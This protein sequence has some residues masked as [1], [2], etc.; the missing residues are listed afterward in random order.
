M[1]KPIKM[2]E[3][4]ESNEMINSKTSCEC[5]ICYE[6]LGETNVCITK[7]GHKF[8]IGCLFRHSERSNDC[9]MCREQI[10]DNFENRNNR[11]RSASFNDDEFINRINEGLSVPVDDLDNFMRR[12]WTRPQVVRSTYNVVDIPDN[13][14]ENNVIDLTNDDDEEISITYDEDENTVNSENNSNQ[15]NDEE[16]SIERLISELN[17]IQEISGV[18]ELS[19]ELLEE[20]RD[21]NNIIESVKMSLLKQTIKKYINYYSENTDVLL[22]EKNDAYKQRTFIRLNNVLNNEEE[23]FEA[24]IN[25]YYINEYADNDGNHHCGDIMSLLISSS[26]QNLLRFNGSSEPECVKLCKK[27]SN[28]IFEMSDE[29]I[30]DNRDRN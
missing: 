7:C 18:Y 26:P 1:R 8:C 17:V 25:E 22:D 30:V 9:P 5:P 29:V 21:G 19:I 12:G 10:V 27:I 3:K 4:I 2:I 16:K 15:V 23:C 20:I 13:D 6:Q 14:I 11:S 28:L 24:Y